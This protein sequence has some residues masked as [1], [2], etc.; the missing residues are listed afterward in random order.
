[1]STM[2]EGSCE[3][4]IVYTQSYANRCMIWFLVAISKHPNADMGSKAHHETFD[5]R[6]TKFVVHLERPVL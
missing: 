2:F 5:S 1:M 3:R 6:M 4:R